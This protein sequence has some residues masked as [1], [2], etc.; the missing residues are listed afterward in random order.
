MH[1]KLSTEETIEY[2]NMAIKEMSKNACNW[3][4]SNCCSKKR[5]EIFASTILSKEYNG[6]ENLNNISKITR[7]N[8]YAMKTHNIITDNESSNRYEELIA[9]DMRG[10]EYD[11]IGN[12]LDFQIPSDKETG[13][14]KI[15][16]ISIDQSNCVTLL[17][18]KDKSNNKETLLRAA[19]EVFTY[20]KR[21]DFKKFLN[22]FK[23]PEHTDIKKAVLLF[24]GT[25]AF[26]EYTKG[27]YHDWD[28]CSPVVKLMRVLNIDFYGI[29][30]TDDNYK[31]FIP[32]SN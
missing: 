3:Y 7:N 17:E 24:D 15:D 23:L 12:V 16:L 10:K 6:I 25:Y 27:Y 20:W 14:G 11:Y 13:I 22:D 2:T 18:L 1:I 9:H 31:V 29:K 4:K 32:T 21:L 5:E 30:K 28:K 8:P 19:L 26:E